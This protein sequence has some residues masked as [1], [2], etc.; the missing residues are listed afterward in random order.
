MDEGAAD[1][2]AVNEGAADLAALDEG[3]AY[4][5]QGD[6]GAADLAQWQVAKALPK[7]LPKSS[8]EIVFNRISGAETTPALLHGSSLVGFRARARRRSRRYLLK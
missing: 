2:A 4:L 7:A 1:L 5:A 6:E 8:G 3:A